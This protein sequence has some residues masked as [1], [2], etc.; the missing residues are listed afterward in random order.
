MIERPVLQSLRISF[1]HIYLKTI[2]RC[3]EMG[4][5]PLDSISTHLILHAANKGIK[6]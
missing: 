3:N 2:V 6:I 5:I 1:Q 4:L